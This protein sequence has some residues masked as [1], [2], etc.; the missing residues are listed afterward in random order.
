MGSSVNCHPERAKNRALCSILRQS[1]AGSSRTW[2]YAID[3]DA[4]GC[5]T[6]R[7]EKSYGLG[8]LCGQG[9]D[10]HVSRVMKQRTA[11]TAADQRLQNVTALVACRAR[12]SVPLPWQARRSHRSAKA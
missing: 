3:F 8:K 12:S 10:C 4:T 6:I 2:P 7:L 5:A 1:A 11:H 9:D